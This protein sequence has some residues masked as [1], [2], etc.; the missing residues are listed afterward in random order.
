M[1]AQHTYTII[2]KHAVA[3][4][5]RCIVT[6][7]DGCVAHIYYYIKCAISITLEHAVTIVD[8]RTMHN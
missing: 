6:V 7:T 8:R 2:A 3:I 1:D 5:G 4:I